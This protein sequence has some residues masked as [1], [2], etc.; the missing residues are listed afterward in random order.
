MIFKGLSL[1]HIRTIFFNVRVYFNVLVAVINLHRK[2][3]DK[4]TS[5]LNS[6]EIKTRAMTY[7]VLVSLWVTFNIVTMHLPA[8]RSK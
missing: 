5:K 1:K 7:V 8:E 3:C 4:F 6:K 2:C